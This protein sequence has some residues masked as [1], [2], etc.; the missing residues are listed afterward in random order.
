MGPG[1]QALIEVHV[2]EDHPLFRSALVRAL[3]GAPDMRVGVTAASVE[4][5]AAYRPEPGAV[6][7]L[8]L[9]LPRVHGAQAVAAVN[10]M[11]FRILVLS[12][13]GGRT[14]VLSALAAGARGYLT[15]ESDVDELRRAVRQVAA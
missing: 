4:E 5:F 12:A 14:E 2:I 6:V 3:D 8:D 1:S 7:T 10:T 13:H 9:R 15:K 11:G